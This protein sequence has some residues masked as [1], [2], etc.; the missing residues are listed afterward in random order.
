MS[1][2][3][4]SSSSRGETERNNTSAKPFTI[5]DYIHHDWD[6]E[7]AKHYICQH[8]PVGITAYVP[9]PEELTEHDSGVDHGN[10][11]SKSRFISFG[12]GGTTVA[13]TGWGEYMQIS[14]YLGCGPSSMFTI[15]HDSLP[16]PYITPWRKRALADMQNNGY[17]FGLGVVVPTNDFKLKTQWLRNRWPRLTSETEEWRLQQ[18]WVVRDGI[19]IEHSRLHNKSGSN[20]L[21]T[22]LIAELSIV[23]RELDLVASDCHFNEDENYDEGYAHGPGPGGYGLVQ[24]HE[25]PSE[26]LLEYYRQDI[27]QQSPDSRQSRH[28][29]GVAVVIGFFVDGE[30]W[31]MGQAKTENIRVEPNGWM[32]LVVGYRMVLITKEADNRPLLTLTTSDLDI[33]RYL[34]ET[35]GEWVSLPDNLPLGK[36]TISRFFVERNVEHI[37]SVCMVP[38]TDEYVW[39][40]GT[41]KKGGE[42]DKDKILA[43]TCGSLSGHRVCHSAG[44]FAF[45]FLVEVGE[46]LP[47]DHRLRNR[48]QSA[49]L[50]HLRWIFMH[51]EAKEGKYARNYWVNGKVMPESRRLPD[52]GPTDTP[53]QILKAYEYYRVFELDGNG[54]EVRKFLSKQINGEGFSVMKWLQQLEKEDVRNA[55]VWRHGRKDGIGY[56]RLDDQAWIWGSLSALSVILKWGE[57]GKK[58]RTNRSARRTDGQRSHMEDDGE[59]TLRLREKYDPERL[60]QD[61][62]RRFTTL[63]EDVNE[64]ML[65][66]T[67]SPYESRFELHSRDTA[68]FYRLGGQMLCDGTNVLWQNTLKA[69]KSFPSRRNTES[70]SPLRYGLGLLMA[71]HG[72]PIDTFYSPKEALQKAHKAFRDSLPFNG[73]LSSDTSDI[74]AED[75]SDY[76]GDYYS[77]IPFEMSYIMWHTRDDLTPKSTNAALKMGMTR[78][79]LFSSK[80]SFNDRLDERNI[81]EIKDEWMYDYPV[82]LLWQPD[83]QQL[84]L[85]SHWMPYAPMRPFGNNGEEILVTAYK[86]F[87]KRID[88]DKSD[89]NKYIYTPQTPDDKEAHQHLLLDVGKKRPTRKS[90][91]RGWSANCSRNVTETWDLLCKFRSAENAKKRLI[92]FLR[93][94]TDSALMCYLSSPEAEQPNIISF[95]DR[96][97]KRTLSLHDKINRVLNVW[98]TEFHCT[99]LQLPSLDAKSP[100]L[101][102]MLQQSTSGWSPEYKKNELLR[103]SASFRFLGDLFDRFWTCHFFESY[104]AVHTQP[105]REFLFPKSGDLK[106]FFSE[107]GDKAWQQRRVLEQL[108]FYRILTEVNRSTSE[109]LDAIYNDLHDAMKKLDKF[110]LDEYFDSHR[111]WVSWNEILDTLT[112]DLNNIFETIKEW[113]AREQNRRGS[114]PRWT[115]RDEIKY[116]EAVQR[117]FLLNESAVRDFKVC[118]T[119]VTSL[120]KSIT[121]HRETTTAIYNQQMNDRSFRQNDNIKYFTYSTVFFLPLSFATS[122][123]SMQA[124][125]TGNLIRQMVVCTV[126]AFV[127]LLIILFTLPAT[128]KELRDSSKSVWTTSKRVFK[129]TGLATVPRRLRQAITRYTEGLEGNRD[130]SKGQDRHPDV[131]SGRMSPTGEIR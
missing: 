32:D 36:R 91:Y 3:S 94:L 26:K 108:A 103:A 18:Q 64:Q 21:T 16:E 82:F 5:S 107:C 110:T 69:Q 59:E 35:A 128:L 80:I 87:Q 56:Y 45:R 131:E 123:F 33:N 96:H 47:G 54:S 22:R 10:E 8:G 34:S 124:K 93:P 44:Y 60:R 79:E 27:P 7:E 118:Q 19:V 55:C 95:L 111:V 52:N 120:K 116:R 114:Q 76:Y 39:D 42:R 61:I 109:I 74:A 50:G 100:T 53:L 1:N 38:I 24:V 89:E 43:L 98:E 97:A 31:T 41:A 102:P 9:R 46:S 104:Y 29:D 49:C 106:A 73:L 86:S 66:V 25:F 63:N 92:W 68:L 30:P 121:A 15:D 2:A 129:W 127:I 112:E 17:G 125:P 65:A 37:L 71:V 85:D 130:S 23:I 115:K 99:F 28:P 84:Y 119:R 62:I 126:V 113:R 13:M 58:E 11:D 67:R 122:F 14:R 70:D 81:V 88:Y 78:Q 77:H 72:A 6:P 90:G 75:S 117:S 57:E 101:C 51:A 40:Y 48:I 20:T 4:V 83:K 105:M 12:D